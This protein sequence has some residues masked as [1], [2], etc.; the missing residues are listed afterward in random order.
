MGDPNMFDGLYALGIQGCELEPDLPDGCFAIF[1]PAA[2]VPSA[3]DVVAV[4]LHGKSNPLVV[5]LALAV[6]PEGKWLDCVPQLAIRGPDDRVRFIG[7]P[8]VKGLHRFAR[9]AKPE[10]L[11]NVGAS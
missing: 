4:W 7:M 1:D 5:R 9:V 6:P 3:G 10:E 2:G 8:Q 11:Y